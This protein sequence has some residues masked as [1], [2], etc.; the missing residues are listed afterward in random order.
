MYDWAKA[1]TAAQIRLPPSLTADKVT[2]AAPRVRQGQPGA[3][4]DVFISHRTGAR[5]G[6][7]L[8]SQPPLPRAQ[9]PGPPSV[10]G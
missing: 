5:H 1:E 6:M 7:L 10:A 8:S 2:L 9:G 3:A 4:P